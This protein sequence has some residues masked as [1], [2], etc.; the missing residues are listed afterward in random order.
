MIT[1][2]DLIPI[3][4]PFNSGNFEH[5]DSSLEQCVLL[6]SKDFQTNPKCLIMI[7]G[8]GHVKLGE[9]ANSVC[10]NEGLNMG[11]MIPFVKGRKKVDFPY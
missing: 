11:S 3:Y 4:V 6:T 10:I 9:W 2:Q 1:K 5:K 8:A 7:Q